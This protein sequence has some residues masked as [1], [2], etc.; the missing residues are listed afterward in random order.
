MSIGCGFKNARWCHRVNVFHG[1]TSRRLLLVEFIFGV[2]SKFLVRYIHILHFFF[3][4]LLLV[5]LRFSILLNFLLTLFLSCL[6]FFFFLLAS[7]FFLSTDFELSSVL[8]L[9]LLLSGLLLDFCRNDTLE[10]GNPF[11]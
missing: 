9:S 2:R 11:F 7:L 8:F 3:D 5:L 1:K 10:V 4:A 6:A